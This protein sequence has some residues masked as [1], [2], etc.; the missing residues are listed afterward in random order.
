MTYTYTLDGDERSSDVTLYYVDYYDGPVSGVLTSGGCDAIYA[1]HMLDWDAELEK[2]VFSL[3]CLP[4][5]TGLQIIENLER[6]PSGP[7]PADYDRDGVYDEL[8]TLL[9]S[10]GPAELIVAWERSA[11]AVLSVKR[12]DPAEQVKLDWTPS[13]ELT[14]DAPQFDWFSYVGLSV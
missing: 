3:A 2:R 1:F 5:T 6:I 10:R 14:Q 12:V 8:K 4:R 11:Q 7:L 13:F 9:G